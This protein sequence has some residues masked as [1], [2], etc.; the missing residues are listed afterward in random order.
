MLLWWANKRSDVTAPTLSLP[1]AGTA[2]S[3]G[4][5]GAGVTTN[6]GNGTLYWAVV[7]NGGSCTDAQLK[8][9]SGGNIVAGVAGNQA[10][11]GTGAQ[12][13]ATITGLSASTTY[14]I[15][16]LQRDAA[17]NDSSQASVDLTTSAAGFIVDS[18][19]FDGTNDYM[20]RG[21]ALTGAVASGI[22]TF[23]VWYKYLGGDGTSQ[24]MFNIV[25]TVGGST[26]RFRIVR[27]NL[28]NWN[29]VGATSA[30]GA[31]FNATF[32]GTVIADGSWHNLLVSIDLS[33]TSKRWVYIDDTSVAGAMTWS[34]YSSGNMDFAAADSSIGGGQGFNLT[35]GDLA[36]FYFAAGQYLDLSV[37]ANRRKFITAGLKPVDLGSDGSTPTGSAPTIYC[38]L[39]DGEA[40]AN[41][42]TNRGTGGNF[43]ITGTLTTG[44]TSPSD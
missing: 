32:T 9:G 7:T 36:E 4:S 19:E 26:N 15:K 6:E 13:I 33:S 41:F 29:F 38:H 39:T 16:F 1:T 22:F 37:T 24:E 43:S 8:A 17:G 28:N 12:T 21:A 18:A 35:N 20:K 3:G 27:N 31:L 10:V 5:T 25:S 34:T 40:V 23:S 42:A 14:Q 44:S 30:G 11:S 2:T